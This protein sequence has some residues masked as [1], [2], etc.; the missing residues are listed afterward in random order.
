MASDRLG[1]SIN[2]L[3]P[4]QGQAARKASRANSLKFSCIRAGLSSMYF[5]TTHTACPLVTPGG[6]HKSDGCSVKNCHGLSNGSG[7]GENDD[8]HN[9]RN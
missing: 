4:K 9:Q 2:H 1:K 3:V 5:T 6:W 8:R 7:H